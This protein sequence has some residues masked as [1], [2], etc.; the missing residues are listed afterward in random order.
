MPFIITSFGRD[1][2]NIGAKFASVAYSARSTPEQKINA[3]KVWVMDSF[4]SQK[5]LMNTIQAAEDLGVSRSE[6]RRV[7]N[8]RLKNKTE[9]QNLFAGRF[10]APTPSEARVK[11]LLERLENQNLDAAL[12]FELGLDVAEDAWDDLKKDVRNFDLND[13]LESFEAFIDA[14]LTFGVKEARAL[15]PRGA[16]LAPVDNVPAVLPVDQNKNAQV[17]MASINT[18][19]LGS[20]YNLLPTDQKF[21]KLFPFG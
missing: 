15:P 6:L 7:L 2:K 13:S 9:V 11:S 20:R 18:T 17:N 8:D 3:Y 5:N 14:A 10:K 19:N 4:K 16:K 1:K 21:D 12:K